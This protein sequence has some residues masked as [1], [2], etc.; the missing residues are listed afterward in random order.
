MEKLLRVQNLKCERENKTIFSN[1]TF[2]LNTKS[3]LHVCGPNG[4]GK[5][6]LLKVLIG[7]IPKSEGNIFWYEN[8][9]ENEKGNGKTQTTFH[10]KDFIYLGHNRA[11]QTHLTVF[12]NLK[13]CLAL[14]ATH[15]SNKMD[16]TLD[17]I[18]KALE[19]WEMAKFWN[20]TCENLSAGQCQ[21]IAL[22]RLQLC[23]ARLWV[24]D[25]PCNALDKGA[26]V[27]FEKLLDAH[28]D[29]GGSSIMVS[30]LPI[31]PSLQGVQDQVLQLEDWQEK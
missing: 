3:C 21:R 30:H 14:R 23:S 1:L 8:E 27:L 6:S 7:L 16:L 13:W 15:D 28:L 24:L 20:T 17:K 22:A 11:L 26:F 5:S 10:F 4:S 25:E 31:R 29:G 12:E 19:Y 18:E 9:N 2:E